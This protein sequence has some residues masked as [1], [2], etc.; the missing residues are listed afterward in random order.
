MSFLWTQAR[1]GRGSPGGGG[2]RREVF[3]LTDLFG[4]H[5]LR[6]SRPATQCRVLRP[7]NLRSSACPILGLRKAPRLRKTRMS[8]ICRWK[9]CAEGGLRIRVRRGI[10]VHPD[11]ME[12]RES[13]RRS[14]KF[15]RTDRGCSLPWVA[16]PV[17]A[18]R[19]IVAIGPQLLNDLVTH[20]HRRKCTL[21]EWRQ[22]GFHH[23]DICSSSR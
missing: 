9:G 2:C 17:S 6:S 22:L 7:T 18:T 13:H 21:L 3:L 14:S 5:L 20:D 23:C 1:W 16:L 19:V 15:G 11:A 12:H 10:P 4:D 8:R